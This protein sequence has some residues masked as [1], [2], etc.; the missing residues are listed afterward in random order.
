MLR[1]VLALASLAAPE[2]KL[3]SSS[4]LA[5]ILRDGDEPSPACQ[6]VYSTADIRDILAYYSCFE[7]PEST[8]T[9]TAGQCTYDHDLFSER[10]R[11]EPLI[12]LQIAR[13]SRRGSPAGATIF[14]CGAEYAHRIPTGEGFRVLAS[15]DGL[16][17]RIYSGS[18]LLIEQLRVHRPAAPPTA[19]TA[20]PS[21]NRGEFRSFEATLLLPQ[22]SCGMSNEEHDSLR[23]VSFKL[24]TGACENPPTPP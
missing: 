20:D 12:D 9:G 2:T 16:E 3:D 10:V 5:T 19:L 6:I 1:L 17:F 15:Y 18:T 21:I 22:P 11:A 4:R 23:F 7:P 24:P 13:V 8:L 14:R